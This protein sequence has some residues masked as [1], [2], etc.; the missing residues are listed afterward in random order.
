MLANILTFFRLISSFVIFYFI[1]VDNFIYANVL[2]IVASFTDYLDGFIARHF[3]QETFIGQFLDPLADKILFLSVMFAFVEKGFVSSLPLSFILSREFF[4]LGLGSIVILKNGDILLG[5]IK[6]LFHFLT[7]FIILIFKNS[8][9]SDT[10]I[11]ISVFFSLFSGFVMYLNNSDK[12]KA[13]MK[14]KL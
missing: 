9:V 3:N 10:F 4:T 2:F 8:I 12:I 13:F 1:K 6:N 14:E 5:K 7:V 11:W